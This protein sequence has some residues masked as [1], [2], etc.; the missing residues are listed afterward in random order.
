MSRVRDLDGGEFNDSP[1]HFKPFFD[2]WPIFAIAM[3]RSRRDA[4]VAASIG[5]DVSSASTVPDP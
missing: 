2:G 3:S 5:G 4:P 1:A